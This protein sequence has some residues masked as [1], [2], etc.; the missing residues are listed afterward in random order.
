[1][2]TAGRW[3]IAILFLLVATA[4]GAD[5]TRAADTSGAPSM[6]F[7]K[8]SAD[9]WNF[10]QA[11]GGA[12]FVPFGANLV[13]DYG[14]G[15]GIFVLT[16]DE[17]DPDAIR[18]AFEGAKKLHM[19]VMKIFVPVFRA[20][21]GPQASE[22]VRLGAMD[23]PLLDRLDYVFQVAHETGIYVS[24]TLAE[25]GRWALEWW[26]DGGEYMGRSPDEGPGVDSYA[27]LG[28]F[29]KALA[30][31]YKNEPALFSYNLSVEFYFPQGAW[32]AEQQKVDPSVTTDE[33]GLRAWRGWLAKKY[34]DV[35]AV[36]KAW[37]TSYQS[38]SE[39][40]RPEFKFVEAG[41]GTGHY[42]VPQAMIADYGS[43][44]E[45]VTYRF[46]K[47]QVDAIR[48][49]DTRHMIACGFHPHHPAVLW[50]GAAQYLAAPPAAE[51]DFLDYMTIHVY[52]EPANY[53]PDADPMARKRSLR[54]AMITARFAH[55]N[56][57]VLVEEMGCFGDSRDVTI[58]G[59]M[60]I[61]KALRG[62]VSGYMLWCLSDVTGR[63][64]GPLDA[65]LEPNAFGREWAKLAEPGGL[66]ADLPT[67]RTPARTVIKLDRLNGLAPIR[68]TQAQKLWDDW[69]ETPQPID[70]AWPLNPMIEKLR[71]GHRE[72]R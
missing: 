52:T 23:P 67:E 10:E 1:M 2:K 3:A 26:Q 55:G 5:T 63:P 46:L 72:G 69:D 7:V 60:D 70:F 17:W 13:F 34:A 28:S 12:R 59:T 38:V 16:Q 31:R 32:N 18:A 9:R 4:L 11:P 39:I 6:P 35:S 56:M 47:A 71:S 30:E 8:V 50:M 51:L 58:R 48:S 64:I 44:K 62:S 19:N 41:D 27:V 66:V 42:T 53:V 40:P 65:D 49:V 43:F 61:V 45:W 54:M 33:C 29:W 22:G 24:L 20:L 25:W 21:P 57:P 36:N 14:T 68:V 37:G 15:N